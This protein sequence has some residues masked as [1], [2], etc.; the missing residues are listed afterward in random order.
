MDEVVRQDDALFDDSPEFQALLDDGLTR[1]AAKREIG[2]TL[3]TNAAVVQFIAS[4]GLNAAGPGR[5]A[6]ERSLLGRAARWLGYAWWGGDEDVRGGRWR[7]GHRVCRRGTGEGQRQL[8]RRRD[9]PRAR[10]DGGGDSSRRR[11]V[12][13][14]PTQWGR[15]PVRSV[16]VQDMRRAGADRRQAEV[17]EEVRAEADRRQAEVDEEV[18]AAAEQEAAETQAL[19]DG[20][21]GPNAA[22]WKAATR[23]EQNYNPV[24]MTMEQEAQDEADRQARRFV[25]QQRLKTTRRRA[26]AEP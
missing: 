8:R 3:A 5:A 4:T 26:D 19:R 21:V 10:V 23:R 22:D 13:R 15:Q 2:N 18:R 9:R 16:G 20:P 14:W 24:T 12:G 7:G 11:R 6:I 1:E 17:D 25:E